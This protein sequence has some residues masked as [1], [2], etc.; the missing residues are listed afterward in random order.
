MTP[1][2]AAVQPLSP[3][4]VVWADLEP[5]RGREQGGRRPAVV[6]ASP[7]Y[8]D[9]VTTLAL[10]VPVTTVDRGWPNHIRLTGA[11]GLERPSWAMTEQLRTI[12][13]TRLVDVSGVA[14]PDCLRAIRI[15]LADFLDLRTD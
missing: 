6:V 11:T 13:R 15:W 8:L 5:V 10:I 12:T 3:G 14:G 1:D 2:V 4:A 9:A 7:G